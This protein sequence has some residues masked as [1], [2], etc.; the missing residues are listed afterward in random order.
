M[1]QLVTI[2]Q[3]AR[4]A[5]AAWLVAELEPTG[6]GDGVVVE[7]RWFE[8]DR[9]LPPRAISII[10]AGPRRIDW[11]DPMQLLVVPGRTAKLVDVTW[12]LG[13]IEQRVQLDVWAQSDVA[14]DDIMA[15]LDVAL[16]AGTRPLGIGNLDPVGIGVLLAL[17]DAWAPGT[18]D[19]TFDEPNTDQT[20][21]MA[22][23][24]EWHA[25]YRGVARMQLVQVATSPKLA[26][27]NL[28]QRLSEGAATASATDTVD[29]VTTV[30]AATPADT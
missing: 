2:T 1:T 26:R 20:A 22:N 3:A 17:A 4:D 18:A 23:Q 11:T 6:N 5:L 27:I 12:G 29:T 16:N 24:S 30:S 25:T 15:R 13:Y 8:V 10:D 7:P 14:L 9:R 28:R 19:F 21:D